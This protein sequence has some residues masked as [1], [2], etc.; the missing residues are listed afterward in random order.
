MTSTSRQLALI[1]GAPPQTQTGPSNGRRHCWECQRR[2][3]VCDSARPVCS[4][5]KTSGVVCPGYEDKKPLTWLA[6]G[7]VKTRTWKRKSPPANKKTD[8]N[9][10]KGPKGTVESE[11]AKAVRC[12]VSATRS[13]HPVHIFP[14][15]ELRDETCDIIEATLYWNEQVYPFF[16]AN[17]LTNSPW[18]VPVS[19]IQYMGVPIQHALVA[20]AIDHRMLRLSKKKNDMYQAEVRARFHQHRCTAI[21][22]LNEEI[23][24]EK[25]R[26]SDHTMAAVVVFLYADLMGSVTASNWRHH[27]NG[28]MAIIEMRGGLKSLCEAAAGYKTVVLFCKIIENMANTTSPA[29]DQVSPLL[30]FKMRD[31]IS[32]IYKTG[33]YPFLPCPA[34]LFIDI[35]DINRLRY[36]ATE[37]ESSNTLNALQTEA[38]DLLERII[39][40]SPENWSAAKTESQEEFSTMAQVYQS[41]VAVFAIASLQSVGVIPASAGWRAVKTIHNGKLFALLEKAAGSQVLRSC[42]MWPMIVAGFEAKTGTAAARSFIAKRLA[43]ESSFLGAYLPLATKDILERFWSSGSRDWD[44]CFDTPYALVT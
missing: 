6:P 10:K 23:G 33:Y 14:G 40:F 12:D 38:E 32:E 21:H 37:Q 41:A 8:D 9:S 31:L 22:A 35:I 43:D 27:L 29:H 26:I 44:E 39:N 24:N 18:L 20:M 5:C 15:Y 34:E 16:A 2:R 13:H 4:K 42:V 7:K 28:F 25:R 11:L 30:N 3:L 17:Q 19:Y 36:L 1:A